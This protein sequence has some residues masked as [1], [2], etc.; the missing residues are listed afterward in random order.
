[1]L[2]NSNSMNLGLMSGMCRTVGSLFISVLVEGWF[3]L[4]AVEKLL[5]RGKD[6]AIP[7]SDLLTDWDLGIVN[8]SLYYLII[9]YTIVDGRAD[10]QDFLSPILNC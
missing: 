4:D 3:M 5:V 9:F 10:F 7:D 8:L 2:S 1:M 6:L